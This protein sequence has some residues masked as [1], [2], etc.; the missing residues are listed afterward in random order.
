[1]ITKKELSKR[2]KKIREDFELSQEQLAKKLELS[3]PTISKIESGKRKV[4]SIELAKYAKIF[5]VTSDD[6]LSSELKEKIVKSEKRVEIPKLNKEKFKQVLLY[7]LE[8][9]GAKPNIG[10][11][12]IYK[13]LYF[14]DFN[15]YELYEEYLTG[16]EYRKI[17][18]GPAPCH[19]SEIVDEM[20]KKKE[21]KKITTEYF[22]MTQK[23]YIPQIKPDL[24]RLS[25]IELKV[26]DE[27]INRLSSM[28][29][30]GIKDYSYNDIPCQVTD[31]KEIIDYETVFYRKA[32]YSVRE[33]PEE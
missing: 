11:T 30:S 8:E 3:R 12:V 4:N 5:G 24:S 33:Y 16:E 14:A 32:A 2:I 17:S 1:M 22:G 13:L 25:A 20:V 19:F 31:N 7:F 18:Y 10:E 9:C 6:L 26:I 29:A 28:N 23:K 21:L 27:V 15:F